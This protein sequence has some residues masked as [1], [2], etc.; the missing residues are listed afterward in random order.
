MSALATFAVIMGVFLV[1]VWLMYIEKLPPIWGLMLMGVLVLVIVQV[2]RGGISYKD[3]YTLLGDGPAK[4]ASTV[5]VF[6]LAGVFARSQID[7]GIVENIVKRAAELG[8]DRPL[9]VA[10]LLGFASAYVTIG[11]FAGGCFVAHVT[12]LPIL[13][14][15]G[16][17]PL[18]AA[19]VQGFGCLQA[20]LFWAPHWEYFRQ[21]V[22]V[23]MQQMT[24]FLLVVQPFVSLTWVGFV[25]YQFKTNKIR[26][27]WA[28][29]TQNLTKIEQRV[30]L[31]ALLCPLVPLLFI[32]V[33]R[34]PP[35]AAFLISTVIGIV[36]THPGSGRKAADYP[37]LFTKVFLNGVNDMNYLI[38]I[39]IAQ[40]VILQASTFPAVKTVLAQSLSSI[41]PS[42]ALGFIILFSV[43]LILGG[44]FRGPA[45]PWSMGAAVI[46]SIVA[47]GKYPV[48]VMGG[49][50][51]VYNIFTILADVT[52]G[53]TVYICALAKISIVTFFKKIYVPAIIYGVIGMVLITIYFK[54]W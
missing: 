18:T 6:T 53:Y 17:S 16:L 36:V 40:G 48:M 4:I 14:S 25:I 29:S 42:H 13:I 2:M 52:T 39:L 28:A 32:L 12:A 45:Q 1:I 31:Y 54:M 51:G 49:L 43:Y 21:Y 27:R 33:F 26:L 46:A 23:T 50:I 15:V 24:P 8:G 20:V 30:P 38:G 47:I 35:I 44:L 22:P 10:L 19:V 3:Y 41:L 34:M 37:S 7:T 9:I 5:L 11:A